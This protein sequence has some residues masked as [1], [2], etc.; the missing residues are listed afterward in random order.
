[1]TDTLSKKQVCHFKSKMF[2]MKYRY[3][4]CW[5][6]S[7]NCSLYTTCP[8][9]FVSKVPREINFVRLC[10]FFSRKGLG[11]SI[12]IQHDIPH[13]F[14]GAAF[15]H[16]IILATNTYINGCVTSGNKDDDC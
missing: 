3:Q 2:L 12:N 5:L 15:V 8:Y 10:Q 13:N 16:Y 9:L 1:M 4:T 6:D 7:K 14:V 11:P